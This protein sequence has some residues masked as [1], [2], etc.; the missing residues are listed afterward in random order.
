MSN[1][2][3]SK[4]Q[5]KQQDTSYVYGGS[6]SSSSKFNEKSATS[7]TTGIDRGGL[8]GVGEENRG[9]KKAGSTGNVKHRNK[10]SGQKVR[11]KRSGNKSKAKRGGK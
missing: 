8:Q 11:Q 4:L 6:K 10:T 1:K 2:Y 9:R 3:Q 5:T 7:K